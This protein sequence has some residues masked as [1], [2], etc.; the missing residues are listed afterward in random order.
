[1]FRTVFFATLVALV[2]NPTHAQLT[3]T[4][5]ATEKKPAVAQQTVD[6]KEAAEKL[7]K[8]AV[9]LLRE[10]AGE[11]SNLRTAENRI[12]FTAELGSL[13]WFHDERE[14]KVILAG[15]FT[16]F[17]ELLSRLDVQANSIPDSTDESYQQSFLF[18]TS[19]RSKI[20]RKFAVALAVRQ[21][22][23]TSIAEHDPDLALSF[24]YD[25]GASV[26]NPSFRTQLGARDSYFEATLIQQIA[27]KNVAKAVELASRSLEKGVNYQHLNLLK[28]VYEKDVEKGIELGQ[29]I[30]SKLSKDGS[31]GT[32][33]TMDLISF[34]YENLEDSRTEGGKKPVYTETDLR[35]IVE[36]IATKMLNAGEED[37]V[38]MYTALRLASLIEKSLPGRATQLRAKF[39]GKETGR[40]G[41]RLANSAS[42]A[43]SAAANAA[44]AAAN[45]AV[46]AAESDPR[47]LAEE[48]MQN[49]L[50]TLGKASLPKE[51][52][53]KVIA[54]ARRILVSTT[55]KDKR[56]MGLS[57]LAAQVARMGDKDLAKEIMRDA[58]TVVNPNPKNY[59]DFILTWMLAGGYAESDPEQAFPILE[60]AI[61]RANG[62]INSFVGV[63]EFIDVNED[64]IADGEI[65][66]GAF[67]GGMIRGLSRELGI[68][69]TTLKTLVKADFDRTKALTNRFDR[70]EARVLAKMLVLRAVLGKNATEKAEADVFQN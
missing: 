50:K 15:V 64:M 54:E 56:I 62:V 9:E 44:A 19:D 32:Y 40:G 37:N 21:Q 24:Y 27:D 10:T 52:R 41:R 66:I 67:G 70:H 28:K 11:V 47:R 38:E 57:A 61:A 55:A 8:Q 12:S 43:A 46:S 42:N 6:E 1:M 63:G 18:G 39:G 68:A 45:A 33:V 16:D 25:S 5:N 30:K 51:E 48:K 58:A 34:G 23:T 31:E 22:I 20:N 14:A 49:D 26:S 69:E 3:V 36:P 17:R 7:R 60:D 35:E 13:M 2:V 53:D 29:K 59:Q 65:Q 4:G